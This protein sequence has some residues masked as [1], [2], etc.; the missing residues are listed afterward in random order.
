MEEEQISLKNCKDDQV[1]S[2][3]QTNLKVNQFKERV[4][5]AFAI[6]YLSSLMNYLQIPDVNYQN[7]GKWLGEGIDCEILKPGSKGWQ[8]GK[9]KLN[10]NVTIEFVSDKPELEE[11][12]SPLDDF[13]QK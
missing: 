1:L 3:E 11:T 6:R 8:K 2:W 13:R 9:I 5:Q 12:E 7:L 10:V 4:K